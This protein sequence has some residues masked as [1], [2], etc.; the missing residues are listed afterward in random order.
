MGKRP[1][2]KIEERSYVKNTKL[3]KKLLFFII[4]NIYTYF[5]TIK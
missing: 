1:K 2:R 4:K 3:N 5:P